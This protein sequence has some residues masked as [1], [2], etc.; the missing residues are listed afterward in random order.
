MH[1]V[2][3]RSWRVGRSPLCS[4]PTP[5]FAI[6][7]ARQVR[8]EV[9]DIAQALEAG[10]VPAVAD[11]V[12]LAAVA[13]ILRPEGWAQVVAGAAET[14][15]AEQRKRAPPV[16]RPNTHHD[17]AARWRPR[18]RSSRTSA[19]VTEVGSQTLKAENADLRRK[20]G[21]ARSRVRDAEAGVEAGQG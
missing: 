13:Y 2:A 9:D 19:S 12:E 7:L 5:T 16:R 15:S 4:R 8:V 6:H 17:C 21:D 11:P 10:T 18:S 20:L 3:A 1:L 14:V